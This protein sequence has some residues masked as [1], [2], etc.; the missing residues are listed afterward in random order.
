MKPFEGK[1]ALI[2][3]AS[4]GIGRAIALRMAEEGADVVINYRSH[5]EEAQE[6]ARQV[7]NIGQRALIWQAD[8]AERGSVEK[9]FAATVDQL[10]SVDIAVAN[11]GMSIRKLVVEAEWEDILRTIEVNQFGTFH[12]CQLAAQQM[13]Q[14]FNAGHVGGKIL[15]ISSVLEEIAPPTSAAYNMAKA[16]VNHLGR[17]MAL[18]LARYKINVNMINPGW[19]DTPG[20][21]AFVDD[22]T[23]LESGKRIPWGR[24]GTSEDIANAAAFLCGADADYVTGATLR[25]DGGFVLGLRLPEAQ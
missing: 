13:V 24:L 18:E 2:T 9:M 8:V 23:I 19:I 14:Q 21:R 25:V 20:E 15:I 11:A 12:T 17:T 1:V 10:G 3:G 5:I 6:V 4:L 16:A 22:A 7:Q